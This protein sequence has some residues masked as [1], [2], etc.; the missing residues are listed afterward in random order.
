MEH[1]TTQDEQSALLDK[2]EDWHEA[3]S[4][5]ISTASE[6]RPPSATKR[7]A[8]SSRSISSESK[9][10]SVA[11]QAYKE[12]DNLQDHFEFKQL[13]QEQK[14]LLERYFAWVEEQRTELKM[15]HDRLRAEM[16]SYHESATED[17][18]EHHSNAL[19]EAEDK[20]VK[21]EA[22][23]REA[24]A[25][26]K[27]D[28]ATALKHMEAYCAG[29]LHSTGEAH[30]RTVTDQDLSELE[31]TRRIRDTMDI[32][33]GSAINVLRGEQSRRMKLRAQRQEKELQELQRT[34]RREGLDFER[35]CNSE[36]HHLDD[37]ETDK[38]KKLR[39]RWE[40]Q[41]AILAKKIEIDAVSPMAAVFSSVDWQTNGEAASFPADSGAMKVQE[42]LLTKTGIPTSFAVSGQA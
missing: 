20:Q 24:H 15:R 34:Q 30:N 3:A 1:V 38:R 40:L 23:M 42:G 17:L 27:R 11:P 8:S 2:L 29:T 16:I 22:D 39:T 32:K 28:N 13:E 25:Q 9:V 12:P 21:G 33:H 41:I 18:L 4:V 36:A 10:D 31:K 14:E 6:I 26:E 35:A 37:V 19:A 7:P 5:A